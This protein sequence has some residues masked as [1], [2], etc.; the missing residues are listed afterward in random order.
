[1]E[2]VDVR[3]VDGV[4]KDGPVPALKLDL[5]IHRLPPAQQEYC[6]CIGGTSSRGTAF[7][8]APV[9]PAHHQ[10]AFCL[11]SWCGR[12]SA[13]CMHCIAA[14]GWGAQNAADHSLVIWRTGVIRLI[15]IGNGPALEPESAAGFTVC[16]RRKGD[17]PAR[18]CKGMGRCKQW[19][20]GLDVSLCVIRRTGGRPARR[21]K[22]WGG[23]RPWACAWSR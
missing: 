7:N 2:V 3:H 8:P 11:G 14:A 18:R 17:R 22:G 19:I 1:M 23:A 20:W 13:D 16:Q 6:I 4:L 9:G 21:R 12:E 5:A 10:I 15:D